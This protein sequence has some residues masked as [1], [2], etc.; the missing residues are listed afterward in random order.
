M[1]RKVHWQTMYRTR[2]S[3][4][5]GWFQPRLSLF[6]EWIVQARPHKAARILDVGD[7]DS[8]LV[9]DLQAQGYTNL[10]LL[11]IAPAALE[12]SKARW[13]VHAADISGLPDDLTQTELPLLYSYLRHARAPWP[14]RAGRRPGPT[15]DAA[16]R[17][18]DSP[19][20]G[21]GYPGL[22]LPPPAQGRREATPRLNRW[23]VTR[24][25][26]RAPSSA[27]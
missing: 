2:P 17:H 21:R 13:G 18:A 12:P 3:G 14:V 4:M 19:H 11:D 6:R 26:A 27:R 24:R 22:Y 1:Q 25:Q 5:L 23:D 8:A 7:D 15:L 16:K 10:T 9:D 20:A